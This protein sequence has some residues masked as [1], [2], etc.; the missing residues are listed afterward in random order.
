MHAISKYDAGT[1]PECGSG[2]KYP[3]PEK[4]DESWEGVL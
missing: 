2:M 3:A 1:R 4:R